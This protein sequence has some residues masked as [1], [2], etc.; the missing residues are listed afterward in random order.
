MRTTVRT[1]KAEAR[2]SGEVCRRGCLLGAF[3]LALALPLNAHGPLIV[4]HRGAMSERPE[5]TLA[6]IGK[7]YERGADVIEV[8]VRRSLDG[9]LVLLHDATLDRT[10]NGTGP[11]TDFTFEELRE[12]DAGSWFDP[13]YAGSKILALREALEWARSRTTLLLDLK[14]HDREYNA[15]VAAEILGYG[16]SDKVVLGVR[17]VEQAR[18]FRELLPDTRQLAFIGSPDQ[19]EAYA[20]AGVDIIRLWLNREGWLVDDPALAD[21]VRATGRKLMV[22]GTVGHLE[23]VRQ[24][25]SFSPD[26]ILIDDIARLQHSLACL[27]AESM[28]EK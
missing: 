26:W 9:Q 27:A 6:A 21:R 14:A 25:V 5:N 18:H 28:R 7:A 19:M 2:I 15:A 4:A 20:E 13:E 11:V 3:F 22:N 23:E 8:D 17:T 1:V 10:T 24:L 12:L 16:D